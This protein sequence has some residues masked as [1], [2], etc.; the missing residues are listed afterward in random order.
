MIIEKDLIISVLKLTKDEPVSHELINKDAKMP[1]STAQEL[2]EKLQSEGLIYIRRG[3]VEADSLQ[4]LKLAVKAVQLGADLEAVSSFLQW[5]EFESIA[6]V[7]FEQ[8]GYQVSKNLRFKHAGRKWEIDVVGCRKP[9]VVCV[10]CK[11]W[12][13]GLYPSALKGIVKDQVERASALANTIPNPNIRI[14]CVSWNKA[15]VIP[16][17]LSLVI[18]RSKFYD[19]VP[20][21]PILQLQDF[22]HQLPAYVDNLRFFRLNLCEKL[23]F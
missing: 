16:V 8:N 20:V 3:F 23:S 11:H 12:H 15:I 5:Q 10:D 19:N 9:L 6:T 21:V 14:S 4:R 18:G 2:L 13:H 22:I 7:A 17:I 1:F